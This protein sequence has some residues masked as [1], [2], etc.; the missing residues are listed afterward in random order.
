MRTLFIMQK[1]GRFVSSPWFVG[2]SVL[3][4]LLIVKFFW[5]LVIY[6]VPLGYD[7]G[8]YRYLFVKHA[9][10][11]PPFVI[12][13]LEPW[14][15]AHP[16]GLFFFTTL[17][18]RAGIPV[19]WFIG[20]IWN[21]IPVLLSMSLS[22]VA[23]K[24]GASREVGVLVLLAAL[25]SIPLF[26]GF[27]A[28]YWK[29]LA[30][31]FWCV[32]AFYFLEK[33]SWI[34]VIFGIL[35][36]AT[37]HQTGLLFGLTVATWVALP[38][39]PFARSTKS[40]FN[41][42]KRGLVWMLVSGA[43]I[44]GIGVL[45]YLPLW[46]DAVLPQLTALLHNDGSASGSFPSP[47]FYL[48]TNGILL[49]LGAYGFW[50]SVHKERWTLWQIAMLWSFLFVALRLFFY[51][52]FF[53]QL[54]FFLLPFAA[55]AISQLWQRFRDTGVRSVIVVIIGVQVLLMSHAIAR[56]TPL[57]D[58]A[59]FAAVRQLAHDAPADAFVVGLENE[60]VV[61]LRGWLPNHQVGGPGL[62]QIYW[63]VLQWEKFL[64]GTHEERMTLLQTFQTQHIYLFASHFFRDYYGEYADAFLKDSCFE[65]TENPLVYRVTCLTHP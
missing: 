43:V 23:Y 22:W 60:T 61:V 6:D 8:F 45:W 62:F 47:V 33:R 36:V 65:Q 63:D 44:A 7:P 3:V 2:A 16:L 53:L 50:L 54:D 27:A 26:D 48:R 30:S 31:L 56:S 46:N 13:D 1:S 25:M 40:G 5:P 29:T 32:W 51:R 49:L 55:L 34:G 41:V 18:I 28:M 4:L 58:S 37:H 21:L 35:A 24:R 39:V 10:G 59:T 19:D 64:L 14:A 12:A 57:V 52:R 38:F 42:S 9:Q 17:F 20:W 15:R 11:F